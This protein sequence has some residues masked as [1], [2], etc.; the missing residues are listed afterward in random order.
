M[1][2]ILL[3]IACVAIAIWLYPFDCDAAFAVHDAIWYGDGAERCPEQSINPHHPL[4][5]GFVIALVPPL[6]ALGVEGPGHVATRIVAG[7]GGAWLLLQICALAGRRRV[8]VGLAFAVVLFC[9][10]GFL[11]E[12]ASGENVLPATAAALFALTQAVRPNPNLLVTGAALTFAGLMRQDNA[13]MAP[14]IALAVARGLPEGKRLR[15]VMILGLGVAAAT[16]AGYLLAWRVNV[17]GAEPFF[18]WLNRLGHEGS[19]SGPKE[20]TLSRLPVYWFS[21]V[22]AMTGRLQPVGVE[23]EWLGL[24]Y[25]AVML[26]P[27]FLLRGTDPVRGMAVPIA[28]TL[29]GRALFHSWY[30]ADNFEWLVLPIAFILAYGAGRARGEPGTPVVARVGGALILIGLALWVLVAHGLST[31]DLRE[32]RLMSSV[33]EA[34]RVDYTKWRFLAHEARVGEA[35]Y[36]IGI[37][38]Y[39]GAGR[40]EG[41]FSYLIPKAPNAEDFF[42]LL[43]LE[44]K[45]HPIQTIV[46]ADRFVMD[47][48]PDTMRADFVWGLDQG[49]LPGWD[50]V[51]RRG[52][53]YAG[54]WCPPHP[55]S[56]QESESRK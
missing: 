41:T 17:G 13:F 53:A 19:W 40:R 2:P 55:G 45:K 25:V 23:P 43:E 1:T 12:A 46:I 27:A 56:G 15:G 31:W 24:L 28:I 36:L 34:A 49:D 48:M 38:Q 5:H 14:G 7:L 33:E 35:L 21:V 10:R 20:F 37:D 32:R 26:A 4:F 8:L 51:R 18:Y 9:T 3:A 47:G 6:R 39:S 29:V 44:L 54:R 52:R 16:V 30:E 50:I 42:D 22:L 11:V